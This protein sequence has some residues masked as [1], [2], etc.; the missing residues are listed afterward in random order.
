MNSYLRNTTLASRE[1]ALLKEQVRKRS[2]GVC[3][4]CRVGVYA[5]THHLTYERIGHERIEDLLA[6]CEPCHEFLSGKSEYDPL[7]KPAIPEYY[8]EAVFVHPLAWMDH[9]N[10]TF[11]DPKTEESHVLET[12]I[13]RVAKIASSTAGRGDALW[14]RPNGRLPRYDTLGGP[15]R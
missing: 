10:W 8:M 15:K 2:G 1:W 7:K 13:K 4:R 9:W 6:V 14:S 3:E 11:S 12:C 5:S